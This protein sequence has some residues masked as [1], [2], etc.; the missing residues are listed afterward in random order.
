MS[1]FGKSYELSLTRNY[2]SKWGVGEAVRELIQNAIDSES[3]FEYE[4][5]TE[6]D[7]DTTLS[8]ISSLTT[9][10]TESLLLGSS[11]KRDNP[12]AIGS[13]GEGFKLAMLVLLRENKAVFCRNG[14]V[15][16]MPSFDVSKKFGVETLHIEEI[17]APSWSRGLTFVVSRLTQQEREQIVGSCLQMQRILGE[18]IETTKGDIL[19]H[20]SLSGRLYVGGLFVCETKLKH[21]YNLRPDQIKLERDRQ[22]VSSFDLAWLVKDMWFQTGRTEDIAQM[23]ADG[24]Q[25]MAHADYGAPELVKEACYRLFKAQH[26]GKVVAGSQQELRSMVAQGL[27]KTV[28]IGNSYGSVIKGSASYQADLSRFGTRTKTPCERLTAWRAA[29]KYY[30]GA[31]ALRAFDALLEESKQWSMKQ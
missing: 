21:G 29:N 31:N 19:L 25:D 20:S 18:K 13:F 2:V 22:T 17:D 26:P 10:P 24:V 8:I 7:G 1:L 15:Q 11:S 30:V 12:D 16:W 9:L 3:P 5:E 14:K 4:W 23:I 6:D 27:V 28:Y